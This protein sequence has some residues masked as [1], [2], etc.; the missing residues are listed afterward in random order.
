LFFFESEWKK[1]E[2]IRKE[3]LIEWCSNSWTPLSLSPNIQDFVREYCE[4]VDLE[5]NDVLVRFNQLKEIWKKYGYAGNTAEFKAGGYVG[6][7]GD[8]AMFLRIQ[9]CNAKQTPDL[10]SVMKVLGKERVVKR[11]SASAF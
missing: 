6:K 10:F 5:T 9:L 1:G 3:L 4:V 2:K 7:V 11:L 8:L